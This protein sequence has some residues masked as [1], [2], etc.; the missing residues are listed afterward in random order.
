MV[1]HAHKESLKLELT[2]PNIASHL[3]PQP[4]LGATQSPT[5][6]VWEG[7]ESLV[8]EGEELL[9]N[10]AAPRCSARASMEA[11]EGI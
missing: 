2:P 11:Q 7:E 3:S 5:W 10:H 8:W 6:V 4:A 9:V 1:V